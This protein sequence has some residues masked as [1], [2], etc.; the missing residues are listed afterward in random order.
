MM[1]TAAARLRGQ[2]PTGLRDNVGEGISQHH[3]DGCYE[4]RQLE[5][6]TQ[7]DKVGGVQKP[8]IMLEREAAGSSDREPEQPGDGGERDDADQHEARHCQRAKRPV[9]GALLGPVA[10][11]VEPFGAQ[12]RALHQAPSAGTMMESAG[13][14]P[15]RTCA[16]T[17]SAPLAGWRK[18]I[19]CP[20]SR[21]T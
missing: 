5:G 10:V 3:A 14:R 18:A 4:E 16:P 17:A 11:R 2:A 9:L 6:G 20:R 12:R 19:S 7:G 21:A 15:S 13:A 1:R 8:C